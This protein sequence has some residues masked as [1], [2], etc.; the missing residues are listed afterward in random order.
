MF[1]NGWQLPGPEVRSAWFFHPEMS[2]WSSSGI[3][4]RRRGVAPPG[5]EMARP[6]S[7]FQPLARLFERAQ[8]CFAMVGGVK[9]QKQ[10]EG[11]DVA[12]RNSNL[13]LL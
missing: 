12:P 11:V 5:Q 2:T 9:G 4:V 3:D 1:C 8:M 10:E 13:G 6:T 7:L